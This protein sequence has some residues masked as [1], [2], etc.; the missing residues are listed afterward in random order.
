[1]IRERIREIANDL[2]I[3]MIGFTDAGPF[4]DMESKLKERDEKGYSTEFEE[5]S[6]DKRIFPNLTL[7]DCRGI[8]AVAIPYD[9]GYKP[10]SDCNIKGSLS[11]SS[12]GADY[13]I[14]LG[15]LL[16]EFSDRLSSEFN[17]VFLPFVD[18]GPLVDRETAHRGGI[19]YYGKNCCII[20][21]LYGSYIFLGYILTTLELESEG[22]AMESQCGECRLCMDA[23]PTG[24]LEAPGKLNPH[25]C[26]SYL[27]Q[28]KE[29]I[30]KELQEKMGVKIYGCDTCQAVCPK[31]KGVLISNKKSFLP[32]RSGGYVDIK[33]LLAMSKKAFLY[34]YG[35]MAGS[36]RGRSVLIRNAVIALTNIGMKDEYILELEELKNR[37][38]ELYNPYL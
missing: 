6:I 18:T 35:D 34:K 28:T 5:S 38:V 37:K 3:E 4:A 29:Y 26:I 21:P 11:K 32:D 25:K 23:C 33:E 7:D 1:M 10:K 27:T 17:K 12:W 15:G 9:T 2:N 16:K 20:N 8:I 19:G 14:V 31:N 13:H 22:L 36:W 24:A 30:P